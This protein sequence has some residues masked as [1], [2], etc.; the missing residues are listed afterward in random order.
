MSR[1]VP[2]GLK[3]GGRRRGSPR[4]EYLDAVSKLGKSR[5]LKC[6]HLGGDT[7]KSTCNSSPRERKRKEKKEERKERERE[8]ERAESLLTYSCTLVH[9]LRSPFIRR[10]STPSSLFFLASLSSFNDFFISWPRRCLSQVR[11]TNPF[12]R[13]KGH[14]LKPK[15]IEGKKSQSDY[16][17]YWLSLSLSLSLHWLSARV[18]PSEIEVSRRPLIPRT[19]HRYLL[20]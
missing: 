7:D 10:R 1:Q 11:S 3:E 12:F 2:G 17:T 19:L 5:S 20:L 13:C 8:R 18:V 14:P 6:S 9:G 15:N 16:L 4:R